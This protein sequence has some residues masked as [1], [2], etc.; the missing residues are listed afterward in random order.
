[1]RRFSIE[2]TPTNE[3]I[4]NV[5]REKKTVAMGFVVTFHC[6]KLCLIS[7]MLTTVSFFFVWS[8]IE[9][10]AEMKRQSALYDLRHQMKETKRGQLN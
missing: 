9:L 8:M 5:S 3:F 1:M 7:I 2:P 10:K 6:I 4:F